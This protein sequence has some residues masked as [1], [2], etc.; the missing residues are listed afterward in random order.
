MTS[1]L[2]LLDTHIVIW[3]LNGDARLPAQYVPIIEDGAKC[4]VS[5][6]SL[7][8]IAIKQ[9]LG[10]LDVRKDVVDALMEGDI[11]LLPVST[12]AIEA[13]R[14]LPHHHRDPFD[15]MLIAQAMTE[16]LSLLTVDRHF[17]LYS[18]TIA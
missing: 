6:A 13:V 16:N 4:Y 5:I 11:E 17:A 12:A 15:R 8:E 18:V 2:F 10:K 7:W 9:S 3:A 1:R 14:T